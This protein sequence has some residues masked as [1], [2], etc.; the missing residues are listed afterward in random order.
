M[1]FE[2]HGKTYENV[3]VC[4]CCTEMKNSKYHE[5]HIAMLLAYLLPPPASWI[6][7]ALCEA[8]VLRTSVQLHTE[9]ARK[10]T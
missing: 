9:N 3:I 8:R 4:Y 5:Y 6:F 1:H 2:K 7:Q 10:A